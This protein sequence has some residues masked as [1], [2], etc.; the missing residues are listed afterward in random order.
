MPT[1]PRERA[2]EKEMSTGFLM[3][4]T[5]RTGGIN[6]NSLLLKIGKG[7][8]TVMK[9][10]PHKSIYLQSAL[11]LSQTIIRIIGNITNPSL[12]ASSPEILCS[13]YISE[14]FNI[15]ALSIF[16]YLNF[17]DKHT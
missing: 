1:G 4:I 14:V 15:I 9:Q 16:V 12:T 8:N 11:S 2:E 5:E 10:S 17:M 3:I 6:R 7:G 13:Y